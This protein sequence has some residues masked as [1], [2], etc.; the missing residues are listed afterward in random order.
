MDDAY[1]AYDAYDTYDDCDEFMSVNH[2]RTRTY[3]RFPPA[4]RQ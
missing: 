3:S 2:F 4:Y 1:D